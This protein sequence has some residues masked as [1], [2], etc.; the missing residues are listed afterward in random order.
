VRQLPQTMGLG[1]AA[2]VLLTSCQL[3]NS[4]TAPAPKFS[5]TATD[6]ASTVP[7]TPP[8][9]HPNSS[10]SVAQSQTPEEFLRAWFASVDHMQVTGET[11]EFEALNANCPPCER[12]IKKVSEIYAGHESIKTQGTR[13]V[14]IK[15]IHRDGNLITF[16]V[17][18]ESAPTVILDRYGAN[19]EKLGGGRSRGHFEVLQTRSA[20]KMRYYTELA[21]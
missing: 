18:T 12:L 15:R 21:S 7:K 2:V 16:E 6:S 13:V 10:S 8:Q 19:K 9:S 11:A 14:S 4:A 17:T 5:T 1:M 20:L 3:A